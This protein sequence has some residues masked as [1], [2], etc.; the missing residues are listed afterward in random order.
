MTPDGMFIEPAK[1]TLPTILERILA[2]GAV[3]CIVA[4]LFWAAVFIIPVLV[5]L[6]V[7]GYFFGRVQMRRFVVR[8]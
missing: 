2:F 3:L 5:V 8:Q 1:P 4:L 6:G 7:V